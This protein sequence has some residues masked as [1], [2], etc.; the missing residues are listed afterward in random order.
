MTDKTRDELEMM[1]K[2]ELI[3]HADDMDV[4]VQHSWRKDLIISTILEAAKPASIKH[5]EER[6]A[7][8]KAE[9]AQNVEAQ[10][11]EGQRQKANQDVRDKEAKRLEDQELS[12]YAG[13]VHENET[14]EMLLER[15]RKMREEPSGDPKPVGHVTEFQQSVIDAEQKAGAEA[16]AKAAAELEKGRAARQKAEAEGEK[17]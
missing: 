1:T 11:S 3:A 4:D 5:H 17:N 16:V 2:D 10:S 6:Q 14:R 13:I 9:H 12:Q 7:K 8:M 15:V